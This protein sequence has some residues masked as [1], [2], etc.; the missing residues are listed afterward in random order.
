M[1][2]T[3]ENPQIDSRRKK[4]VYLFSHISEQD[5]WAHPASCT[6]GTGHAFSGKKRP[7]YEAEKSPHLLLRLRMGE[8]ILPFPPY[9]FIA[10]RGMPLISSI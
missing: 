9:T 6:M 3:S 7:W 5:S 10:L 8:V 1:G 4:D 2:R